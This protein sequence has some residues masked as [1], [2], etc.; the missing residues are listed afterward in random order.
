MIINGNEQKQNHCGFNLE[1]KKS[2]FVIAPYLD[3]FDRD[4]Q[5]E[6]YSNGGLD[7]HPHHNN[8]NKD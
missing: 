7:E 3:M 2:H 5:D 8:L 1:N 6:Q 4:E